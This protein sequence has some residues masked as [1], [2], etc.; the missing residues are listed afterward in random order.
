VSLGAAEC[1]RSLIAD[2]SPGVLREPDLGRG[3]RSVGR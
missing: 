1:E 2:R 3:F